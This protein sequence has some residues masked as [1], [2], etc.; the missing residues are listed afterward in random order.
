MPRLAGKHANFSRYFCNSRQKNHSVN[1]FTFCWHLSFFSMFSTRGLTCCIFKICLQVQIEPEIWKIIHIH[2]CFFSFVLQSNC[3]HYSGIF[4]VLK[5]DWIAIGFFW[6]YFIGM[7][8]LAG[9]LIRYSTLVQTK[10]SQ[11]LV[12]A[13]NLVKMSVVTR[14]LIHPLR[15]DILACLSRKST[16]VTDSVTWLHSIKSTS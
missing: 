2:N 6:T 14:R 4:Q 10:I 1:V 8:M 7:A 3:Y 12:V 13:H 11:Q 16:G 5:L 9:K 15:A